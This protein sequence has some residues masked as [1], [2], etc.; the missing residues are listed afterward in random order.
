MRADQ[1]EAAGYVTATVLTNRAYATIFKAPLNLADRHDAYRTARRDLD[2][3]IT[4]EPTHQGAHFIRTFLIVRRCLELRE[5]GDLTMAEDDIDQAIAIGPPAPDLFY[6]AA[7]V[8]ALNPKKTPQTEPQILDL[9]AQSL[10]HGGDPAKFTIEA[11][12][13][14]MRPN[15]AFRVAVKLPVGPKPDHDVYWSNPVAGPVE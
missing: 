3:A 4:L 6:Y 1:A 9:I 7:L 13:K 14:F 10:A 5:T 2:R 11:P 15:P 12:F 8:R